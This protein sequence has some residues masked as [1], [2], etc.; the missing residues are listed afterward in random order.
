MTALNNLG[1]KTYINGGA[2]RDAILATAV[3]GAPTSIT[4]SMA[5]STTSCLD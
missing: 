1:Y 2:V 5:L 4:A 3:S